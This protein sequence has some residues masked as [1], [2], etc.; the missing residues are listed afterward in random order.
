MLRVSESSLWL[1][2]NQIY[3]NQ[4][5]LPA[6]PF[7][8]IFTNDERTPWHITIRSATRS[9]LRPEPVRIVTKTRRDK[10]GT[11]D[12]VFMACTLTVRWRKTREYRGTVIFSTCSWRTSADDIPGYELQVPVG[13]SKPLRRFLTSD[14]QDSDKYVPIRCEHEAEPIKI[15]S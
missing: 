6:K 8:E 13:F 5:Y 9:H 2:R 10:V 4:I 14:F 12:E 15:P 11:I 1:S 3:S 7:L